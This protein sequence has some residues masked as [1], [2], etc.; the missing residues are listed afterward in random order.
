[1]P[2]VSSNGK[3]RLA[4]AE[5]NEQA[6]K[7]HN[8]RRARLEEEG[9]V[10]DDEPVPF[11]CECDDPGCARPVELPLAEYE[12]AVRPS[13]RFVVRPDHVDPTVERVV[14]EHDT[15]VVVSKPDLQRR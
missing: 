3:R 14:E 2:W 10:P 7:E 1:V 6:F 11:A 12:R 4:R 8:E 13:D 15:F 5:K 9:G